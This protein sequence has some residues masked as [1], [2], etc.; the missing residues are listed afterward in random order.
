MVLDIGGSQLPIK[1]RTKSWGVGG[2]KILDLENPHNTKREPDLKGDLNS[3]SFDFQ[4]YKED[5][6]I[7]FCIEV[8]EYWWNP[9]GALRNI[10]WALKKDGLLYISVHSIYPV[11]NPVEQDYLRYTRRGIEK[12]L[13]EVGIEIVEIIPR[14]EKQEGE[15]FGWYLNEGMR[16]AKDY[17]GHN[18]VG[19]LIKAKRK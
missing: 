8:S 5:F 6:D 7:V 9:V 10:R 1:G 11:H 13:E 18:E 2:Y 3:I 19:Y 12:L 14:L 4:G 17:K 15:L 16:P